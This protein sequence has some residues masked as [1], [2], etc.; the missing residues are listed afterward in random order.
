MFVP[1]GHDRVHPFPWWWVNASSN[2]M[3]RTFLRMSAMVPH[4]KGESGRCPHC[5]VGWLWCQ[6]GGIRPR[7]PT[8]VHLLQWVCNTHR[9]TGGRNE[10][11]VV[12]LH[13]GLGGSE[14]SVLWFPSGICVL[15][16]SPP[17]VLL[18][19]PSA[20]EQEAYEGKASSFQS[21]TWTSNLGNCPLFILFSF[22]KKQK[23]SLKDC[24]LPQE[25]LFSL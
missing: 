1:R 18:T 21:L 4:G 14:D 16:L 10:S 3:V 7:L 5:P 2:E 22:S 17:G 12:W 23:T 9:L 11:W 6:S 8:A 24:S 15:S 13:R 19:H 20:Y 25:W